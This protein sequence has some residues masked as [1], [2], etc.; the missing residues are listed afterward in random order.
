MNDSS[1]AWINAEKYANALSLS[2]ME[3][4]KEKDW[5]MT[6]PTDLAG[7]EK[8]LL[9]EDIYIFIHVQK[10]EN[11]HLSLC[12]SFS[13]FLFHHQHLKALITCQGKKDEGKKKKKK[14][15]FFFFFW[16]PGPPP[17][18]FYSVSFTLFFLR[19]KFFF[20]FRKNKKTRWRLEMFSRRKLTPHLET[21]Q[22]NSFH[23]DLLILAHQRDIWL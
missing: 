5:I 3:G 13:F 6:P 21:S 22:R 20:F 10:H 19:F 1:A 2:C 4:K 14:C 9:N 15:F 17:L 12:L 18:R 11:N 23:R 8:T 16:R 7:K